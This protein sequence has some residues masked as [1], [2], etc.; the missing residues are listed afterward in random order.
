M[1]LPF[2]GE[3]RNK[4]VLTL[5]TKTLDRIVLR[6]PTR[7][8]ALVKQANTSGEPDW[9]PE[10]GYDPSG[11]DPA[12]LR[13]MVSALARLQT[14]R[15]L[16]HN[17]PIAAEAGFNPPRLAVDL[18]TAGD[19][20][21]R[22]LEIGASLPGVGFAAKTDPGNQG[23][24]FVLPTSEAWEALVKTPRRHDDLPDDAFAN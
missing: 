7:T 19:P 18:H 11:F 15:Y 1:V 16:Q 14:P 6:W 3:L 20:R 22:V 12:N 2:E 13:A 24:V 8:L 4:T 23:T 5:A 9:R 17:G 10:P 21:P